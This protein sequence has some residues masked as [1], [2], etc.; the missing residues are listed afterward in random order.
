M[1]SGVHIVHVPGALKNYSFSIML[2]TKQQ[3]FD[4]FDI[5]SC[6]AFSRD[7]DLPITIGLTLDQ[8]CDIECV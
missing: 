5:R 2:H 8:V 4:R 7:L 1:K 3:S 6:P